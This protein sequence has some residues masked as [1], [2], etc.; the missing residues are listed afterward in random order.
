MS[1]KEDEFEDLKSMEINRKQNHPE[2]LHP[3][4]S[5]NEPDQVI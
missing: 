1:N 2:R 5:F 4:L 3:E